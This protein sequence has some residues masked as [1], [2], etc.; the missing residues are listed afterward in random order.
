MEEVSRAILAI[1]LVLS[2]VFVPIAFIKGITGSFYR[3]FA[4]T[5]ASSILL[6]AFVAVSLT[7]A[8]CAAFLTKR[9]EGKGPL[10]WITKKFEQVFDKLLKGYEWLLKK[11]IGHWAWGLA[12]L[13]AI[14]AC[15]ILLSST[16]PGGLSPARIKV[17]STSP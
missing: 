2:F 7:P 4:L 15:T 11:V 6:S 8:M 5:L 14:V 16:V 9:K 13:A 3:Q 17:I 1:A 10:A 12:G